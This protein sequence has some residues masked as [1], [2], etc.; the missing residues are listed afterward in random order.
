MLAPLTNAGFKVERVVSPCN[1][2][3]ALARVKSARGE[4]ATCWVAINRAGVAIVVVRPGKQIYA[5]SFPWDS[6]V[7]FSGSQARL[8]QRYSLVSFLS[9]EIKRAMAEA[10][11]NGFPVEAVVTCGNLPDLRSLTMPL[12]EELDTE[13][14]TLDSLEGLNVTPT[15]TDGLTESAAAIRLACAGAIARASRRPWDDSRRVAAER[16]SALIRVAAI[17]ALLAGL[18]AAYA[19]YVKWRDWRRGASSATVTTTAPAPLPPTRRGN[20]TTGAPRAS[21]QPPV[22]LPATVGLPPASSPPPAVNRPTAAARVPS[23][24]TSSVA[25]SSAQPPESTPAAKV[26]P[27]P[28][29]PPN[30]V[31]APAPVS[32]TPP[33]QP[34]PKPALPPLLTDPLPRVTAILV[35]N[36]RRFA[37][38]DGGQII[39]IGDAVGRRV[40]VEIDER[41]LVLREPSGRRVRVGLGGRLL[42]AARAD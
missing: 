34:E 11:A 4:G 39:G 18:A 1:A 9:P 40:V 19:G 10:R 21:A 5:H 22:Q 37:T 14:E 15:A 23:P 27:V 36:E 30:V 25:P 31:P 7:G 24:T 12:I 38:V 17:L 13:V 42:G 26:S 28:P 16:K 32:Q 35:S 20:P 33:A 6:T 8:L 29:P 2:L 3:A 41:A